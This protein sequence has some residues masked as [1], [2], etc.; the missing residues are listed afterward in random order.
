VL[1]FLG[2]SGDA[3]WRH[4]S[5]MTAAAMLLS[6]GAPFWF[7]LLKSLTNLRSSVAEE[8]DKQKKP[9]NT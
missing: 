6:L 7:N 2:I 9:A 8:I 5:G 3:A 4:F 1:N